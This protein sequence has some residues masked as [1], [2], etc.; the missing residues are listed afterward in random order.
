MLTYHFAPYNHYS[1]S[2]S[3]ILALD[4]FV[5]GGKLEVEDL[6]VLVDCSLDELP[7]QLVDAGQVFFWSPELDK[8]DAA[9]DVEPFDSFDLCDVTQELEEGLGQG[10]SEG[11]ATQAAANEASRG[12]GCVS[13]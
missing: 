5:G 4:L 10:R 6:S 2:P 3:D 12:K 11:Q 13:G 8:G 1:P 9:F 7:V